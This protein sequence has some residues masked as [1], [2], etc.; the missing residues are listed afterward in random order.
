MGVTVFLKLIS[1]PE[2]LDLEIFT[3]FPTLNEICS[4]SILTEI[5]KVSRI[6]WTSS[7]SCFF[8][9][10]FEVSLSSTLFTRL[11]KNKEFLRTFK[12]KLFIFLLEIVEEHILLVFPIEGPRNQDLEAVDC[13]KQRLEDITFCFE[14][15]SL[16]AEFRI[17]FQET[18]MLSFEEFAVFQLYHEHLLRHLIV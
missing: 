1:L 14:F 6:V 2:S 11:N 7:P 4:I 5:G 18:F 13:D 17:L 9:K 3:T 12:R 10:S 8:P 15:F 16:L